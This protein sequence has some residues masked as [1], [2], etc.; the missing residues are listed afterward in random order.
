MQIINADPDIWGPDCFDFKPSRWIDNDGELVSPPKG[1]FMPWSG[2]PRICPGMK[3]AQVEFVATIAK[4]FRS[5][6]CEPVPIGL[7]NAADARMRLRESIKNPVAQVALSI[8]RPE[9][10]NPR[11][12]DL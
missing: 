7:E 2:G 11:W 1:T 9:K 3:M 4:L 8:S 12:G 10:M 5:A 6:G